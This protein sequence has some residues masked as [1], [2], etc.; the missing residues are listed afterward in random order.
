MAGAEKHLSQ[1]K[2]DSVGHGKADNAAPIMPLLG[3][4]A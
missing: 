1:K 2:R 3:S 4:D